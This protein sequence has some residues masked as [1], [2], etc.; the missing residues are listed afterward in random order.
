MSQQ[1]YH[2]LMS[3]LL[4]EKHAL[5]LLRAQLEGRKKENVENTG[6]LGT[7]PITVETRKRERKKKGKNPKI[8]MKH[9][10]VG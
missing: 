3:N 4:K 2:Q 5:V 6:S 10:L 8:N 9:W 7:W 1:Q